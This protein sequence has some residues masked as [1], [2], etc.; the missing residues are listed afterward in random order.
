MQKQSCSAGLVLTWGL[1]GI[2]GALLTAASDLVLLGRPNSAYSFF[3]LGTE[4]MAVLPQWRITA[5]TFIGVAALPFQL[6]GLISLYYGLKPAGRVI[7]PVVLL[8]TAHA[9]IMGVAFHASYAFIGSGWR[10]YYEMGQGNAAVLELIEK[11]DYYWRIIII[12]ALG[13]LLI[14]SILFVFLVLAGKTLY[15]KWMSLLNPICIL[16]FMYCLIIILPAPIGGFVAPAYINLST[17]A[18]LILST[19]TVYRKMV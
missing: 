2:M 17:I 3:K 1:V 18:F 16:L 19:V 12:A 15:P 11:F 9:L 6:A 8:T 10:L 4:T 7:P 5:G 13:E 14:A